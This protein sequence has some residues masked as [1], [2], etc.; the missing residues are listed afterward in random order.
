MTLSLSFSKLGPIKLDK[1]VEMRIG[2]TILY[3]GNGQGKSTIIRAI[4]RLVLKEKDDSILNHVTQEM[5][6]PYY[7]VWIKNSS[8]ASLHDLL[9]NRQADFEHPGLIDNP[10]IA[11]IIGDTLYIYTKDRRGEAR[12]N[13]FD[14]TNPEHLSA[15]LSE[16]EIAEK[17]E[18]FF[19]WLD[20]P[21]T[22]FYHGYYREKGLDWLDIYNLPYGYRRA[23]MMIYA[24]EK[25]DYLFIEGFEN[26]LH[27]DLMLILLDLFSK[28]EG[29]V[30]VI[31]THNSFP[32][33]YGL[34]KK[35]RVYYIKRS[36]IVEI[37]NYDQLREKADL[38]LRELMVLKSEM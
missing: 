10:R 7:W 32:I 5:N 13:E 27:I 24:L 11:R 29:K 36:D 2:K 12:P 35:W 17:A 33:V 37:S 34:K 3:G 16:P 28:M 6:D 14:A 15:I 23:L 19:A 25:S 18:E 21:I 8:D 26:G 31:E 4:I 9:N 1:R 20:V 22:D 38:F 30:I